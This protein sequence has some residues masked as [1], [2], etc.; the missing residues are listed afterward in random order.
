MTTQL[1]YTSLESALAVYRSTN[2]SPDC[3]DRAFR[4]IFVKTYLGHWTFTEKTGLNF[5]QA[6]L[7]GEDAAE[8]SHLKILPFA[9]GHK[10]SQS[11]WTAPVLSSLLER[12]EKMVYGYEDYTEFFD[13]RIGSQET[14]DRTRTRILGVAKN[15]I[16][17][18]PPKLLMSEIGNQLLRISRLAKRWDIGNGQFEDSNWTIT[19]KALAAFGARASNQ[20]VLPLIKSCMSDV[21][22]D[23]P[24]SDDRLRNF[25]AAKALCSRARVNS[26]IVPQSSINKLNALAKN[27]RGNQV[28]VNEAKELLQ[29]I[30]ERNLRVRPKN[31][32]RVSAPGKHR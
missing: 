28:L 12:G 7:R 10:K 11:V 17:K 9:A 8:A 19:D 31:K 5:V 3:R 23:S 4:E 26:E 20:V 14:F 30:K 27:R 13:D 18:M 32:R 1:C 15:M 21:V 2:R 24:Y 22:W 16:R 29:I 25:R 6:C